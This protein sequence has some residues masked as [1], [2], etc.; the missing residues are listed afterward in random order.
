VPIVAPAA[1]FAAQQP[2]PLP[3]AQ[4]IWSAASETVQ[5][6]GA[7]AGIASSSEARPQ[8][9]TGDLH[10]VF[11]REISL[12]AVRSHAILHLF[13]FTRYRLYVNGIYM[14]R[15]P[16]RYQNQ[17]P[18][19]DSRDIRRALHSGRNTIVVLVH[20]DAPTGRIMSHD[21]GFVASLELTIGGRTE[22]IP[23]DSSWLSMPE[24]SFGPRAQAWASIAEHVDSRKTTD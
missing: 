19:R 7:A 20:R 6:Q 3:S 21:P 16:S 11:A 10:C 8:G 12:S 5:L 2:T 15:G 1:M 14:G 9:V 13:A 18:E 17:R 4:V 24:R 22:I 23:T